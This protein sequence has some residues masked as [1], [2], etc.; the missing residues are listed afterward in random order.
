MSTNVLTA[1]AFL[2]TIVATKSITV[3]TV[4]MN[5]SANYSMLIQTGFINILYKLILHYIRGSQPFGTCVPPNQN[6][7]PLRT[8]KSELYPLCVP[9]N[10]KFY[11]NELLLSVFFNFA[12]PCEILLSDF[13]NFAYPLWA[14]RVPLGVC[15]PQVENRCTIWLIVTSTSHLLW[16]LWRRKRWTAVST[17]QCR[18]K[19]VLIYI[20]YKLILHYMIDC[21]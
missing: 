19:Q 18:S 21:N 12:Y 4:A 7:T 16:S 15:V 14:S 3:K 1:S 20:L 11:T 9:P 13:L 17:V 8:P 6:F 2:W 10:Q 5:C